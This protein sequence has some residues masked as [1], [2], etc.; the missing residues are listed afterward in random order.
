MLKCNP[1]STDIFSKISYSSI[2]N[3][4]TEYPIPI[5]ILISPHPTNYSFIHLSNLQE[6][7]GGK[8]CRKESCFKWWHYHH[9]QFKVNVRR[10]IKFEEIAL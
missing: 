3:H 10:E 5:Y 2:I 4:L 7:G 9:V 6:R 8:K 1:M